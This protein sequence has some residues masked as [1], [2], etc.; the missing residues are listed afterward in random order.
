MARGRS[1]LTTVTYIS[2]RSFQRQLL[3]YFTV[4]FS[5]VVVAFDIKNEVVNVLLF[6]HPIGAQQRLR[7]HVFITN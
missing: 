5:V 3:Y 1:R 2:C 6:S 7:A 4:S